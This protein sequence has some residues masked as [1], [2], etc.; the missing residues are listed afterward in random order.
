MAQGDYIAPSGTPAYRHGASRFSFPQS[1]MAS[2]YGGDAGGPGGVEATGRPSLPPMPDL[3]PMRGS[4]P[5][6]RPGQQA[7]MP[8]P[9]VYPHSLTST[10]QAAGRIGVQGPQMAQIGVMNRNPDMQGISQSAPA[11]GH[12]AAGVPGA[13]L[14]PGQANTD[15]NWVKNYDA[16]QTNMAATVKDMGYDASN[17]NAGFSGGASP[18]LDLQR[19]RM[20]QSGQLQMPKSS[21]FQKDTTQAA[22]NAKAGG[23]Q[24]PQQLASIF[25]SHRP[26][27]QARQMGR[28]GIQMAGDPAQQE[29]SARLGRMGMANLAPMAQ[30]EYA[31]EQ[32]NNDLNMQM[33]VAQLKIANQPQP[34]LADKMYSEAQETHP[35]QSHQA[36][37]AMVNA[38]QGMSQPGVQ[39]QP[40]PGVPDA[41]QALAALGTSDAA[42]PFLNPADGQSARD[43][44]LG[45]MAMNPDD[46]SKRNMAAALQGQYG[47]DW[48]NQIAPV[49]QYQSGTGPSG[50]WSNVKPAGEG[51]GQGGIP[52]MNRAT[53]FASHLAGIIPSMLGRGPRHSNP[54]VGLFSDPREEARKQ[55]LFMKSIAP[56]LG[57]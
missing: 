29:L 6:Y 5:P 38:R 19:A 45:Y 33:K 51:M 3:A 36:I 54:N 31:N 30:V 24:S 22:L 8:G 4:Q 14:H 10:G 7:A 21:V 25:G 55:E 48:Q 13:G 37:Q 15:A 23:A 2:T 12:T 28:P 39:S 26:G 57:K 41:G 50:A 47:E 11:E 1:Q 53:N 46:A 34:T 43:K 52:L 49:Q 9:Q 16:D 18:Q 40:Q 44:W 27:V 17:Q 56:Y 20:L 32:K 42:K 35:G